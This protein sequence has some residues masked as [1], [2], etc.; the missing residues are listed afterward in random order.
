MSPAVPSRPAYE[1]GGAGLVS[2]SLA[3]LA[4]LG[5]FVYLLGGAVMFWQLQRRGLPAGS[6][7]SLTAQRLAFTGLAVLAMPVVAA[8]VAA[9]MTWLAVRHE[10]AAGPSDRKPV[11]SVER[12]QYGAAI[13]ALIIF[14]L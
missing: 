13:I 4:A 2:R 6:A 7:V 3:S 14:V 11:F 12:A 9:V 5:A 8:Y 1:A 10:E